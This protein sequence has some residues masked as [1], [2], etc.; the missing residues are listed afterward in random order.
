MA[1]AASKRWSARVAKTSNALDL[2]RGVFEGSK[3]NRE[4]IAAFGLAE[5]A[6]KQILTAPHFQC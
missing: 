1:K 2:D 6:A 3:T 4:I 5:Q